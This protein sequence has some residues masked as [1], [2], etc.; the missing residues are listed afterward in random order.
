MIYF[1]YLYTKN[2]LHVML[3]KKINTGVY[4]MSRFLAIVIFNFCKVYLFEC[5]VADSFLFLCGDTAVTNKNKFVDEMQV[6]I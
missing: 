1:Y 3:P 6:C 4:Y 5:V 2:V